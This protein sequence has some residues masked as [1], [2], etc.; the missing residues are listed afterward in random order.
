MWAWCNHVWMKSLCMRLLRSA[1]VSLR[2]VQGTIILH[3]Y[4][5]LRLYKYADTI[6]MIYIELI[7]ITDV[8]ASCSLPSYW[9]AEL[10]G[11]YTDDSRWTE[12]R[13]AG[14]CEY[15]TRK[16]ICQQCKSSTNALFY[17]TSL[18]NCSSMILWLI[19]VHFLITGKLV[20]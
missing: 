20:S 3:M 7:M 1:A 16:F 11:G 15:G 12:N 4:T 8:T 10:M 18:F 9:I 6:F 2:T 17:S 5:H 14:G 19:S 13:Q